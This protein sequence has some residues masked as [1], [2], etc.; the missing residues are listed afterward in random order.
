MT[1]A[2]DRAVHLGASSTSG[3]AGS[4][5]PARTGLPQLGPAVQVHLALEPRPTDERVFRVRQ[6]PQAVARR[7]RRQDALC[8]AEAPGR[9]HKQALAS[10]QEDRGLQA[11]PAEVEAELEGGARPASPS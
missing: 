8:P 9:A 1:H 11:E 4:P 2:V 6:V 10:E 5:D 3:P 7:H